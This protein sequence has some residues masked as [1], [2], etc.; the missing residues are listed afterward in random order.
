M[1]QIQFDKSI[2][3]LQFSNI[4]EY[5]SQNLSVSQNKHGIPKDS[6]EPTEMIMKTC[7]KNTK[8]IFVNLTCEK[9][10]IDFRL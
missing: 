5:V 8:M 2:K 4:R 3:Q 7:K 10:W 9:Y 6:E 1:T